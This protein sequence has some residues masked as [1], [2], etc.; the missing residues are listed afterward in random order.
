MA[1]DSVNVF[2]G[3]VSTSAGNKPA[4]NLARWNPQVNFDPPA[5]LAVS[6][7]ALEEDGFPTFRLDAVSVT[8]FTIRYSTNM[9][10]WV[11]FKT[12]SVTP[13]FFF[14]TNSPVSPGVFYQVVSGP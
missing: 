5:N 14:A 2:V 8:N 4:R 12:N 7:L 11:S 1:T 9:M 13:F 6:P 3:G 10:D